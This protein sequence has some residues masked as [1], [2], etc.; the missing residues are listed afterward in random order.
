MFQILTTSVQY[1]IMINAWL[2]LQIQVRKIALNDN[3]LEDAR[4]FNINQLPTIPPDTSFLVN[5]FAL[6]SRV[7]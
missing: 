4:W 3:E 1:A 2:L 7:V 6:I 5:L